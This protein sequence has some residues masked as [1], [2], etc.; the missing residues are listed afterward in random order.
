MLRRLDLAA[1]IAAVVLVAPPAGAD[2]PVH[3]IA[4]LSN[5][6]TPEVMQSWLEG[7]RERGYVVGQNLQIEYRYSQ[8]QTE[9]IPALWL[10][11]LRLAQKSSSPPR[12]RMPSRYTP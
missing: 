6:E 9:R 5:S 12:R 1:A 7:L 4:V 8:A 10:S 3:R 11:S 2:N